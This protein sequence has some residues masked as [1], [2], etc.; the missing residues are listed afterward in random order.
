MTSCGTILFSIARG[1]VSRLGSR[2]FGCT[3]VAAICR[4]MPPS[5]ES[6]IRNARFLRGSDRA[7]TTLN[8][9]V[10]GSI[11]PLLTSLRSH[12]RRRLPAAAFG[13]GGAKDQSNEIQTGGP[14]PQ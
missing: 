4:D 7:S 10:G 14:R 12:V 6:I 13:E 11:P 5:A 1:L 2:D 8:L 3:W 9:R